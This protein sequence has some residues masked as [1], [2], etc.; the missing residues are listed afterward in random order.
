M[1]DTGFTLGLLEVY[2]WLIPGL[3]WV[4]S[5]STPG[6]L[7][8][9]SEFTLWLLRLNSSFTL[10]FDMYVVAIFCDFFKNGQ[11]LKSYPSAPVCGTKSTPQWNHKQNL[12]EWIGFFRNLTSFAFT[13]HSTEHN[14]EAI[15]EDGV[16]PS[17]RTKGLFLFFYPFS[18]MHGGL[19]PSK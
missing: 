9:C 5:G 18:K 14:Y 4:Y 13:L 16:K 2:F 15:L 6:L 1:V 11:I 3:L 12:L 10:G 8:V 7:W 17:Y 19:L